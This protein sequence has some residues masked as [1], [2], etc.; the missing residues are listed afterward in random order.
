MVEKVIELEGREVKV[1][2]SDDGDGFEATE[3]EQN[4]LAQYVRANVAIARSHEEVEAKNDKKVW[5]WTLI[6]IG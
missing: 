5:S 2:E 1:S 3:I 6:T 4:D